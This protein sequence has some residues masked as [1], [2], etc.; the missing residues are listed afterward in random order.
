MSLIKYLA[1]LGYGTRRDVTEMLAARRVTESA[2][3]AVLRDDSPWIHDHVLVD[4][5]PLDP[6]PGSLLLLHKPAGYTCSARD[7]PPLVYDVLPRRFRDRTPIVAPVGRLDRD[8]SGLLLLTDDGALNHQLTSPKRHVSK[9]YRATLA[10]DI[11]DDAVTLFASGTLVLKRES[12]PLLPAE[13]RVLSPRNVEVT[14]TEG[15]YHQVRRMFA[16]TGN[17]VVTLERIA[18]GRLRLDGLPAGTWRVATDAER[19]Q[20]TM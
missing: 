5:A 1:R 13:L 6:P 2:T 7:V 9:T 20:L 16:A 17:R 14:L 19:R 18:I 4:G 8:T 3:A 11:S 10:E 15:R 12:T